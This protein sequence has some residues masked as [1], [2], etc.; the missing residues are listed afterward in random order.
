MPRTEPA[1][2]RLESPLISTAAVGLTASAANSWSS[3]RVSCT[4]APA[5]PSTWAIVRCQFALQRPLVGDLLLEVA[6]PE[7]LLVEQL[8]ARFA[9]A[10]DV[11]FGER[12]PRLGDVAA[13]D[14]DR[15]AAVADFVADALL[16]ED[17]GDV[18][19][20]GRVDPRGQGRV[21]L[22]GRHLEH[23]VDEDD[24]RQ[25]RRAEGDFPPGRE[26]G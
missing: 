8:E 5:T 25:R 2:S 22:R 14:R 11:A 23:D 15:G 10:D 3:G 7:L 1:P 12:D 21:A 9:A 6:G 24:D 20:F 19:G 4:V 13:G 17:L 26:P 16:F 18:A